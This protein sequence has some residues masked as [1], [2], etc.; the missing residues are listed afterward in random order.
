MSET[1]YS[2]FYGFDSPP[3]HITPDTSLLFATETHQQALG[4]IEYGIAAGKGFIVITGEVGVGKTTVLRICLDRLES[5]KTKI[6]YLF[7]PALTIAELYATIL[8]ELDDSLSARRNPV[9]TLRRLQRALLA[10][11]EAGIQVILAVDEAQNMPDRTLESLRVLS[12]LETAKSKLL[13]IILVGQPELEAVLA[14]HSMRQLAQRVAVRSRIVP[15]T[16]GQSRRYIQ[17]RSQS[18][19]RMGNRALFTAPALWYIAVVAHGIPRTIN[20]CCDNAL[21][22]GYGHGAERISLNIARESC[23]A[24]RIRSPVPRVAVLASAAVVLAGT[25]FSG[26]TLIRRFFV[27]ASLPL[28]AAESLRAPPVGAARTAT[29]SPP[30]RPAAVGPVLEVHADPPPTPQPDIVR[31]AAINAP[32][33]AAAP[34]AASP[35]AAP[36]SAAAEPTNRWDP[37]PIS[38]Q[39]WPVRRGDTIIKACR[40]TYGVCDVEALR[41]VFAYNPK[42]GTDGLIRPGEII[43]MPERVE[44]VHAK[45]E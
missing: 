30:D 3:F 11:H 9:D 35:Q 20:I 21:I 38:T 28:P 39:Q 40:V 17:H 4:A 29:A 6:I 37:Q 5:S 22:N 41:A 36:D 43:M 32:I 23:R 33:P 12:N 8:E 1:Y 18:A 24:L 13:Q 16:L 42:V 34:A 2:G 26:D 27:A 7:N 45:K 19:R 10:M 15:L 14:K 31:T 25:V 44:P